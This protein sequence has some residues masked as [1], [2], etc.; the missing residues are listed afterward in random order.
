MGSKHGGTIVVQRQAQALVSVGRAFEDMPALPTPSDVAL[1]R[2]ISGSIYHTQ[3]TQLSRLPIIV[4]LG[5]QTYDEN[6]QSA[7]HSQVMCLQ[8]VLMI[9]S[10]FFYCTTSRLHNK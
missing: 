3:Q 10:L 6:R 7:G 9:G 5:I 8:G 2:L 1:S 4:A